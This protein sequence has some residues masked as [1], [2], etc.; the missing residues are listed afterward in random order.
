MYL[1]ER[2]KGPRRSETSIAFQRTYEHAIVH[3]FMH[4]GRFGYRE[5]SKSLNKTYMS[6]INKTKLS[7]SKPN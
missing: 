7:T 2:T 4:V 3:E 6:P 1:E 5:K